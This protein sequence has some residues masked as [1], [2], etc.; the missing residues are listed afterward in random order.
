[1]Q[2]LGKSSPW[3]LQGRLFI[4]H[5]GIL[6]A[7]VVHLQPLYRVYSGLAWRILMQLCALSSAYKVGWCVLC[8]VT[9]ARWHALS[10]AWAQ[11]YLKFGLP[12]IRPFPAAI[13]TWMQ[14]AGL[15]TDFQYTVLAAL[16]INAPRPTVLVR[17]CATDKDVMLVVAGILPAGQLHS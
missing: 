1:M 9:E 15:T 3:C 8:R 4:A 5:M 17:H 6:L 10:A 12:K 16:F 2:Q 14:N 7:A 11:V 13:K